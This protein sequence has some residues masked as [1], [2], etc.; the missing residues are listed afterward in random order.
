VLWPR[1]HNEDCWPDMAPATRVV[2]ALAESAG[3]RKLAVSGGQPD[4]A[5]GSYVNTLKVG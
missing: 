1:G 4:H 5:G 2:R 3:T